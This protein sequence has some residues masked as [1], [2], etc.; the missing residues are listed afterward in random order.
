MKALAQKEI[1][2]LLPAFAGALALAILPAWLLPFDPRNAGPL[3]AYFFMF[4][5]V[6][7]ALSSFGREIGLRTFPFLLAQPLERARIWWTKIL[8]LAVFMSLSYDAWCLSGSLCS[9]LRHELL[10]PPLV[11]T[12]VGFFLVVFAAGALWMT[13]LLRQTVA[14][15]WLTLFLPFATITAIQGIGG[16]DWMVFTA[17]GLYAAAAFFLARWQFLRLQDTAWTG[18]VVSIGRGRA[19]AEQSASR[20]HRPW[21]ALFRKELQLQQFTLAGIAA[22]FVLHLGVVALRKAGAHALNNSV[23]WGLEMFG[24]LWLFVPLLAGGQSVA[25]ERQLG[26][27]DGLLSLPIPRRVQFV[28]KLL[29]VLGAGLLSA[30]LLCASE[31]IANAMGVGANLNVMGITFQ[32]AGLVQVFLVFL[33]LSLLGFYA[34]TLTRGVVPALGAGGVAAVVSWYIHS[35]ATRTSLGEAFG[36]RLWPVMAVP[37]LTA[38]VVWLAYGNFRHLFE[39]GRRWRRNILGLAAVLVLVSGAAA[40]VYHRAWEWGMLL[41]EAHGPAR[42]PAG[43]PV[44]FRSNGGNGLAAVLPDGRLWEDRV[45]DQPDW[46]SV[47]GNHFVPGS[48]WVDA[49]ANFRE[50]VAIRSDGTLWVSEKPRRPW[51]GN[52]PAPLEEPPLEESPPLVQYGVETNWLSLAHDV[53]PRMVL[54]KRDGTLWRWGTNNYGKVYPRLRE[55]VPLRLGTESDW[56]RI[57][58]GGGAIYAW[59]QDGRAWALYELYGPPSNEITARRLEVELAPGTAVLRAPA[60]D[61]VQFQ[62]LTSPWFQGEITVGIRDGGTLWYMDASFDP[63]ALNQTNLSQANGMAGTGPGGLVQIGKDSDWA[64]VASGVFQLVALKADGSIWRWNLDPRASPRERGHG[65][66]TTERLQDPPERLGSHHDWVALGDAQ[67]ETVAL[68]AD[69]A[70]WCWPRNHWFGIWYGGD[71]D[72][73]GG[74]RELWLAPSRRPAKIENILGAP[75]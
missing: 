26:T 68:S 41:E 18:G 49:Y 60:L 65:R 58:R 9:A 8:V 10:L 5:I 46:R 16:E 52:S 23:L 35:V 27:L 22:L 42:L 40:A 64:A 39:S 38:A 31:R 30:A 15:F 71:N 47:G 62:S 48:N 33:A 21:A 32:G 67:D 61:H 4:G 19:D 28:I 55:F 25:D 53:G 66:K 24:V 20:E 11:L 45:V 43:K 2:L 74:G 34:S 7:L 56:A 44:L 73:Y 12:F 3:T 29:F 17:L 13:L 14:A 70:L 63:N 57:L 1:R 37:A 69:G 6:L 50:T 54:L 72:W 36:W 75:E 51:N 59:K